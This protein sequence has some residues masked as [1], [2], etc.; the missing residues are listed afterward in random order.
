MDHPLPLPGK[1]DRHA[2][3]DIAQTALLFN[4]R[5]PRRARVTRPTPRWLTGST[6]VSQTAWVSASR[7]ASVTAARS[8]LVSSPR[9]SMTIRPPRLRALTTRPIS[10]QAATLV[11]TRSAGARLA[12]MSIM[13][14][15]SPGSKSR[16]SP[17]GRDTRCPSSTCHCGEAGSISSLA[18]KSIGM[19]GA[20]ARM[21]ATA[22]GVLRQTTASAPA[23]SAARGSVAGR[24]RRALP[25][26]CATSGMGIRRPRG[27]L[28][29]RAS[30]VTS[31]QAQA[32]SR[33]PERSLSRTM[34]R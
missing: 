16:P 23:S 33:N 24:S 20:A 31:T 34:I 29:S 7:K 10:A 3:F 9:K 13:V 8:A 18:K 27:P 19:S 5:K 17:L 14:P 6:S 2:P 21:A 4:Q 1:G 28:S 32:P 15:V 30:V 12:L 26:D 25:L 22:S 11:R